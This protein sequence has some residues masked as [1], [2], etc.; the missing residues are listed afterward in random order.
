[1][2]NKINKMRK[3]GVIAFRTALDDSGGTFSLGEVTDLLNISPIEVQ[4][5]VVRKSLLAVDFEGE[6]Q[7][8]IWQ[9]VG[10]EVIEELSELL[11]ILK[12]FSPASV[13]LF[14]LTFDEDLNCNPIQAIQSRDDNKLEMVFMLAHQWRQQTAR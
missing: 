6:L 3:Q 7:F 4:G 13:I 11:S 12:E 10:A 2:N 5:R 9:F 14:F 1:M 8:P